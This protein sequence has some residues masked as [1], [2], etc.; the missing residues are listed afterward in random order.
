MDELKFEWHE[1][2]MGVTNL[3]V[4][5]AEGSLTFKPSEALGA[6]TIEVPFDRTATLAAVRS[7]AQAVLDRLAKGHDPHEQ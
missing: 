1:G 6:G 5:G 3:V 4:L 7:L 2:P